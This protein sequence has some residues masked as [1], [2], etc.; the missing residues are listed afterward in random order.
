MFLK[1]L[2]NKIKG[3]RKATFWHYTIFVNTKDLYSTGLIQSDDKFFPITKVMNLLMDEHECSYY[4]L[5][6]YNTFQISKKELDSCREI[7]GKLGC[8]K[9]ER[10]DN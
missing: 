7:V 9:E 5:I 6:V 3:N 2:F 10:S 1:K 8:C 4:N